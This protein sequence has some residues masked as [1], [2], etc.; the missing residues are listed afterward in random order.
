MRVE[1]K[2]GTRIAAIEIAGVKSFAGLA[3][4]LPYVAAIAQVL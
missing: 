2:Q 1:G 4:N 3:M